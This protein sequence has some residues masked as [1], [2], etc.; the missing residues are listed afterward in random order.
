MCGSKQTMGVKQ[1]ELNM[2]R[3]L[4]NRENTGVNHKHTNMEYLRCN[5]YIYCLWNTAVR[6][7]F[8]FDRSLPCSFMSCRFSSRE[9]R[10]SFF[11]WAIAIFC[12]W[13]ASTAF[14]ILVIVFRYP[15]FTSL[16]GVKSKLYWFIDWFKMQQDLV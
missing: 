1:I 4:K 16:F 7:A 3:L 12:S 11:R 10:I 5:S 14:R 2:W 9:D 15:V 6:L 13:S 8:R